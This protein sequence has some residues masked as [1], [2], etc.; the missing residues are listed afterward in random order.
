MLIYHFQK[1]KTVNFNSWHKNFPKVLPNLSFETKLTTHPG[2]GH[3]AAPRGGNKGQD[4]YRK[5]RWRA[6][7]LQDG[8]RD[9]TRRRETERQWC[10]SLTGFHGQ[11]GCGETDVS[12]ACGI[13]PK[14]KQNNGWTHKL[15]AEEQLSLYWAPATRG[16]GFQHLLDAKELK[17]EL[18]CVG[19]EM[20][21]E[22]YKEQTT[23]LLPMSC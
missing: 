11:Q 19:S 21:N 16:G 7:Q 12:P 23:F 1:T 5:E 15:W 20:K 8:G 10:T 2:T 6:K 17:A 3:T 4:H 18:L 9:R 13:I 14:T 22:Q